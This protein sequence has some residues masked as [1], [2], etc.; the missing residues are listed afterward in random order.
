MKGLSGPWFSGETHWGKSGVRGRDL[1]YSPHS[2]GSTDV[3]HM[4]PARAAHSTHFGP[5]GQQR[6]GKDQVREEPREERT[7]S[8]GREQ[9]GGGLQRRHGLDLLLRGGENEAAGG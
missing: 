9:T 5:A 8:A 7:G 2:N 3:G 4:P 1:D 6:P